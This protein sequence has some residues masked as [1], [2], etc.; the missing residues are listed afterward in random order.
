[1]RV[2]VRV[3]GGVQGEAA[4]VVERECPSDGPVLQGACVAPTHAPTLPS[5]RLQLTLTH[6]G[7]PNVPDFKLLVTS[8]CRHGE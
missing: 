6:V 5:Q 2:S 1:M 3:C 8:S 7:I 4:F